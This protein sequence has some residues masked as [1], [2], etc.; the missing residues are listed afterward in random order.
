M[1]PIHKIGDVVKI[2]IE[3]NITSCLIIDIIDVCDDYFVGP[4][5]PIKTGD[6]FIYEFLSRHFYKIYKILYPLE[7][8][9]YIMR[10]EDTIYKLLIGDKKVW[11]YNCLDEYIVS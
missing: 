7:T 4:Y 10:N 9:K 2:N 1:K 3:G 5:E 8:N 11:V 6:Y